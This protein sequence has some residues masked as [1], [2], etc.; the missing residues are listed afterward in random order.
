MV[1]NYN[2]GLNLSDEAVGYAVMDNDFN[3]I[4]K[5]GKTLIGVRKFDPAEGKEDRRQIRTLRRLS[6]R[7]INRVGWL[8]EIFEP[9][10]KQE[11]P[12]FLKRMK[13]SGLVN[14]DKE[15]AVRGA[16]YSKEFYKKYPTIYHLRQALMNED[17][18]FSVIEIYAAMHHIVK[19]RGNH[20]YDTPADQFDTSKIDLISKL[21]TLSKALA[22]A[23][24][25]DLNNI[26]WESMKNVLLDNHQK[27]IKKRKHLNALLIEKGEDKNVV[28]AKKALINAMIGAKANFNKIFPDLDDKFNFT[29]NADSAEANLDELSDSLND[30]QNAV[31]DA[32]NSIWQDIKL[33]QILPNGELISDKMVSLYNKHHADL[34]NLRSLIHDEKLD[35]EVR[36]NLQHTYDDYLKNVKSAARDVKE[37][38]Y[39]TVKKNLKDVDRPVV[40]DILASIADGTFMPKLRTTDNAVLPYQ[41]H[42]I[43]MD[44]I[45]ENQSKFYPWLKDN[46]E[47]LDLLLS[48]H[49]PYFVGPLT[50]ANKSPF[51]WM[52]RKETGKIYP[53]NFNQKVDL[54]KT[55]EA[56][57]DRS[58]AKD[59]YLYTEPV[60][61]K[62]SILYQA[63]CVLNEINNIRIN[64]RPMNHHMKELVFDYMK[65]HAGVS[66]N[67]LIR[68]YQR[69]EKTVNKPFISGLSDGKKLS[70]NF[71]SYRKMK[72]IFGDRMHDVEFVREVDK[73]IL[74]ASVFEDKD[75]LIEKI[76][77]D[78]HWIT[79]DELNKV[80]KL[81]DANTFTGWG[82]LSHKLLLDI[83]DSNDNNIMD[84]LWKTR[85]NFQ[86]IISDEDFAEQINDIQ[87]KVIAKRSLND[88][89]DAAYASPQ[90]RK[91]LRQALAVVDEVKKI[92]KQEPESIS[93]MSYRTSGNRNYAVSK[94]FALKHFYEENA[95]ALET[96][97]PG[98]TKMYQQ[99]ADDGKIDNYVYLY[100]AQAGID[101]YSGEKLNYKGLKHYTLDHIISGE[102]LKDETLDNLILTNHPMNDSSTI[103][104][105][106][107]EIG[108]KQSKA[109]N[110]TNRLLW[111]E[112][113]DSGLM[114][115]AKY[116]NLLTDPDNVE[117]YQI[118]KALFTQLIQKSQS[119]KLLASILQ[120]KMPDVKVMGIRNYMVDRVRNDNKLF[121]NELVNDYHYGMDAY[122]S[123]FLG[124]YL[125][126]RYPKLESYFVYGQYVKAD[127][128]D[129]EKR[130]AH[131]NFLHDL[132]SEKVDEIIEPYSNEFI[133]KRKELIDKLKR[134][135]E[136]KFMLISQAQ[137]TNHGEFYGQTLFPANKHSDT[138]RTLVPLKND[139]D[140][141]DYGG[142]SAE[143][144]AYSIL[145]KVNGKKETYYKLLKV[146]MR[147]KDSFERLKKRDYDDYVLALNQLASSKL[148]KSEQ[149]FEVVNDHVLN[150]QLI[151]DDGKKFIARNAAYVN[152]A[153]QLCL[154]DSAMESLTKPDPT[155]EELVKVYDDILEQVNARFPLYDRNG[156]REKLN[157]GF[158]KFATLPL[159][160]KEKDNKHSVLNRVLIG[161]HANNRIGE[162][163]CLG[164]KTALGQMQLAKGIKLTEEAVFVYQS[165]TGYYSKKIKIANMKLKK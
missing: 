12:L 146:P 81:Y 51:A 48:F 65:S 69:M 165:V 2:I 85:K 80:I 42:Q 118:S 113:H 55:A 92:M 95:D 46:Q 142:F 153:V 50:E 34:V 82:R 98:I 135:Y 44:K 14:H 119:I 156:F 61:P 28:A 17:H 36:Q 74:Y 63:Y 161:L 164:L 106:V 109:I 77:Q 16:L 150:N 159:D 29:L 102:V 100:F 87:E 57:I 88:T 99:A 93:I 76:K 134:A 30:N 83:K 154:P 60:L 41:A 131:L 19:N 133:G 162:L 143:A 141:E 70:S 124:H 24:L 117:P 140:T 39:Y 21:E 78:I 121:R 66:K 115:N 3:L 13:Q 160:R 32:L 7:K 47:K 64:G 54:I 103:H 89:F 23:E 129:K 38:F 126:V 137:T 86:Q 125:T 97:N 155:D 45:I 27:I 158:H 108:N 52:V 127:I 22:H 130:L 128:F 157:N 116:Q 35:E 79:D 40:D 111:D 49:I 58:R 43:E 84:L 151:I 163:K 67:A 94:F 9:Y 145:V 10:L 71:N 8:N 15:K 104:V 149:D 56:F 132:E 123:T 114:S 120:T 18:Q 33:N 101:L 96:I 110:G 73:I 62:T 72:T 147:F 152:N 5:R 4:A 107:F 37:T 90:T 139:K 31:I 68:I 20:L 122:I 136:F 138:V 11:D 59:T 112:L 25:F 53:W 1:K 6:R 75:I 144:Q 148:L 91:T 105:P 26:D